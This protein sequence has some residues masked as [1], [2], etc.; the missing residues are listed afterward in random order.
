M[1]LSLHI[2]SKQNVLCLETRIKWIRE[3]VCD[4]ELFGLG[5]R[6]VKEEIYCLR[7][8]CAR[9]TE[10]NAFVFLKPCGPQIPS[11]FQPCP[12]ILRQFF[13]FNRRNIYIRSLDFQQRELGR[14]IVRA[15]VD[16]D[17]EQSRGRRFCQINNWMARI[18]PSSG[19]SQSTD[20]AEITMPADSPQNHQTN[21]PSSI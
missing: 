12:P 17:F 15:G 20:S 18:V 14:H 7:H 6:R 9:H 11:H 19:S 21:M 2:A 13:R 1:G 10:Q 3:Y 8:Q 5:V 16:A 4:V